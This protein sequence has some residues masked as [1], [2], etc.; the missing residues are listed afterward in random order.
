[1]VLRVKP[2]LT[3]FPTIN[4]HTPVDNT[5]LHSIPPSVGQGGSGP[6]EV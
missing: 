6:A 1:M 4:L 2:T 3:R 5:P